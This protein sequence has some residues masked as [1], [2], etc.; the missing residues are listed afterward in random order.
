M[1]IRKLVL[2]RGKSPRCPELPAG[3]DFALDKPQKPIC[4]WQGSSLRDRAGAYISAT[5]GLTPS[6]KHW[7]E[8]MGAAWF[9]PILQ[10]LANGESVTV[11]EIQA[12]SLI[13]TGKNL[14][15]ILEA[16]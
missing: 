8:S 7:L 10:R 3:I 5:S 13:A 6:S 16:P 15:M 4:F 11:D 2:A 9:I 12:Q 1:E 14:E